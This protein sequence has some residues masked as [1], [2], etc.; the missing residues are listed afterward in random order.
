MT[1][2]NNKTFKCKRCRKIASLH[3]RIG[4]CI[5][6]KQSRLLHSIM[7]TGVYGYPGT[8][9]FILFWIQKHWQLSHDF[10]ESFA[11]IS[12]II[13]TECLFYSPKNF[14]SV[15]EVIQIL[16]EFTC[17]RIFGK[18]FW[19]SW[20]KENPNEN[21]EGLTGKL[22]LTICGPA[23]TLGLT[24]CCRMTWLGPSQNLIS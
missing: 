16:Q 8:Y 3:L 12:G 21:Y 7:P 11:P 5:L 22:H 1:N 19:K 4:A 15:E 14:T 17:L 18:S 24:S 6:R 9:P 20:D 2:G 13:E 10:F 23:S